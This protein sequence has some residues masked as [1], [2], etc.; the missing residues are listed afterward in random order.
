MTRKFISIILCS[1]AIALN[2]CTQ[3][4]SLFVPVS[5]LDEKEIVVGTTKQAVVK[6]LGT[7]A[8]EL[9][10]RRRQRD[11]IILEYGR[12]QLDYTPTADDM[13]I[14][15]VEPGIHEHYRL[16]YRLIFIDSLL[17]RIEDFVVDDFQELKVDN[18]PDIHII[19]ADI[20]KQY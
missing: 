4:L 9:Q 14:L 19:L 18:D 17:Y 20:K 15:A 11:V 10:M 1:F 12:K 7:A 2:N 16:E 6:K 3:T 5:L 8:T 13:G